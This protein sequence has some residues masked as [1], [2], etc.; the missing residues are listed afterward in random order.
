MVNNKI[1]ILENSEFLRSSYV[2]IEDDKIIY[3]F[4]FENR[5]Q[6]NELERKL[7]NEKNILSIS[8]NL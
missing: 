7:E 1:E 2:N 8:K 3:K 6:L 4:E 5:S